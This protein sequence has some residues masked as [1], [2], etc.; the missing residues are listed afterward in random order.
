MKVIILLIL[1]SVIGCVPKYKET[2]A[3]Q[4]LKVDYPIIEKPN[5][6]RISNT[7]CSIVPKETLLTC[8]SPSNYHKIIQKL[9]L[10]QLKDKQIIELLTQYNLT[11]NEAN[12]I[13]NDYNRRENENVNLINLSISSVSLNIVLI[14]FLVI[15]L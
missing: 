9:K 11:V 2:L 7:E 6:T 3:T 10:N 1:I 5:S 14:L 8:F 13:I 15:A 4:N 12:V